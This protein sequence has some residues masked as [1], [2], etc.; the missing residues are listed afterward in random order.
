VIV[1]GAWLAEHLV[2]KEHL[3]GIIRAVKD[4]SIYDADLR[5]P[6]Y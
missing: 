6:G 2:E 4:T 3:L 5:T 1:T